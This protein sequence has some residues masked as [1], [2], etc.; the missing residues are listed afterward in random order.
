MRLF[1]KM[2]SEVALREFIK[3][4]KEQFGI[5]LDEKIAIELATNL[6]TIF[7]NIYKP[8]KRSWLEEY[9]LN[10]K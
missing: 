2:V 3:I 7:N 8:I 5:I 6:L 9:E 4:Y 1:F 10:K